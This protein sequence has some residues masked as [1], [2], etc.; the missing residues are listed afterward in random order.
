M[1]RSNSFGTFLRSLRF[2]LGG[3]SVD[4]GSVML[5]HGLLCMALGSLLVVVPHTFFKYMLYNHMAHEYLRL[6]GVLNFSLGWLVYRCERVG[7]TDGRVKRVIAEAFTIGYLVQAAVIL[8]AQFSVPGGHSALHV[9]IALLYALLGGL[10]GYL[11]FVKTIKA[12]Q[13]PSDSRDY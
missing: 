11:R 4:L 3:Y 5:A 12:F 13:L 8:R 10:Y 1:N 9:V 7:L 2:A 6:Y